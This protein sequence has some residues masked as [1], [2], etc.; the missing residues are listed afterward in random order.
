MVPTNDFSGLTSCAWALAKAAA[1]VPIVSLD[2]CM[3]SLRFEEIEVLRKIPANSAHEFEALISTIRTASILGLGGS[4]PN[5]RGGSPLST[6]R[7]N[8]RSAVTMRC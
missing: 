6:Q 7:Q 5:R 4:T 3:T 8:F 1:I 2:C